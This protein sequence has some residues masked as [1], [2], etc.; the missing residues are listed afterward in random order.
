MDPWSHRQHWLI[1]DDYFTNI[2]PS[3]KNTHQW[4]IWRM[5][6]LWNMKRRRTIDELD[7]NSWEII[8]I[9]N[10]TFSRCANVS[11]KPQML[12]GWILECFAS[13]GDRV[14]I[15]QSSLAVLLLHRCR[16]D[17]YLGA[18]GIVG[19]IWRLLQWFAQ[20]FKKTSMQ[21]LQKL[22]GATDL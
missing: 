17:V 12:A 11:D 9:K 16:E 3:K 2:W 7:R 20:F 22:R 18:R 15:P 6:S 14:C 10:I 19:E 13:E 21:F 4:N 8:K 5:L 1:L